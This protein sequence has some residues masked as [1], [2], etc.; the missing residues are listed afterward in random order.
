ME[1]VRGGDFLPALSAKFSYKFP[2][3]SNPGA[4]RDAIS[5][6]EADFGYSLLAGKRIGYVVVHFQVGRVLLK[7]PG[8]EFESSR[9]FR[10]FA[11]ELQQNEEN[12]WLVQVVSQT[13]LF[14]YP[15]DRSPGTLEVN[16]SRPSDLLTIGYK[17]G[18]KGFQFSAGL[19]EDINSSFNESDI[20]FIL[21]LG[22]QW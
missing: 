3:E 14:K 10:M 17:H 7:V 13:R 11:L 19:V 12:A 8:G 15:V 4:P 20:A 5:S 16:I 9:R 21:E 18:G 1:P 2:L 6:G 22:W